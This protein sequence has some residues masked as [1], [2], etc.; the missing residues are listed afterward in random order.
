MYVNLRILTYMKKWDVPCL[1]NRRESKLGVNSPGVSTIWKITFIF[2]E[3]CNPP[4]SSFLFEVDKAADV[5]VYSLSM[6]AKL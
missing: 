4:D 6:F 5:S 2:A 3:I 1:V